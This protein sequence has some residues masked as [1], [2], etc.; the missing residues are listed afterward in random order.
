MKPLFS[1]V[2]P[3]YNSASKLKRALESV[4]AQ[5]YENFEILVMDDGSTDNTAEVVGSLADPRIIYEWDKNF[6]G[7]ARPR[8]R[9]IALAKGEWICFLDADD[10]WTTDKLQACFDC[11]ND[12][13]DLVYHNLEIVREPPSLFKRKYAKSRQVKAPV[14]KDLLLK[15]N[16]IAT[17]SVVVRK[18]LLDKIGGINESVEMIACED[19]NAWLR[20]AQLTDQFVYLPRRLGYYFIHNQSISQKDMSISGRVAVAEFICLLSEQQKI[21]LEANHKNTRGRFNYLAGNYAE[22]KED[23]L[24]NLKYGH[25]MLK[26]KAALMLLMMTHKKID[27]KK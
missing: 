11:I 26:M 27:C 3:T 6:G 12:K 4:L 23:L 15:G 1:V 8:N 9:G 16:A 21:E 5:S 25:L 14:L 22:A 24:F 18:S 10:W 17:T 20:V 13:V 7:P 19:Y 2:I